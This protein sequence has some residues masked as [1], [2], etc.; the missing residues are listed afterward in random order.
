MDETSFQKH[1]EYVTV[2][3]DLTRDV[4]LYVADDRR[5]GSLA[6]FY[7]QM[8]PVACAALDVIAMDM[9]R[10]YIAATRAAVPSADAKIVF[11]K[12]HVRSEERR[13]GKECA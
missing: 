12:L 5:E 6:A 13:V 4:V 8:G 1:H 9:W 7:D 11:D 2:V 10:P 3:C